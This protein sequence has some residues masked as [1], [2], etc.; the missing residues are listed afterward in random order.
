MGKE[1]IVWTTKMKR[2]IQEGKTPNDPEV[3]KHTE[4]M[5]SMMKTVVAPHLDDEAMQQLKNNEGS[6]EAWNPY[7]FPSSFNKEEEK[8]IE[9]VINELINSKV[10][11][12]RNDS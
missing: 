10:T 8:F 1:M 6:F 11:L 4:T 2:F 3:L 9:K 7:L 12:N 5:V